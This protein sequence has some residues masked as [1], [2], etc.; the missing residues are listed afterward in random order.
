MHGGW[1][2]GEA[3]PLLSDRGPARQAVMTRDSIGCVL[4]PRLLVLTRI[5]VDEWRRGERAERSRA[6]GDRDWKQR[7]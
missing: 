2:E 7:R 1:R 5:V 3:N 4:L 6:G